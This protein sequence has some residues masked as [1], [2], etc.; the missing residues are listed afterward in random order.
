MRF[1]AGRGAEAERMAWSALA[2]RMAALWQRA[3]GKILLAGA[4]WETMGA[5]EDRGRRRKPWAPS[6]TM[7]DVEDQWAP[8]P[9]GR[10]YPPKG[11][12]T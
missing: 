11:T 9:S 10:E 3:I 7:R 1:V 5:I 12:M 8:I 6:K 2:K 4:P